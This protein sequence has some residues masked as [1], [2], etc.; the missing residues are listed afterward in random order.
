MAWILTA[1][2]G[3]AAQPE[4]QPPQ[5]EPPAT[6]AHDGPHRW[7]GQAE[8]GTVPTNQVLSPLGQQIAFP[9]RPTALAMSPDGRF[10]GV[11]CSDQVV[12]IDLDRRNIA[13]QAVHPGGS[14]TGIVFAPGGQTLLASSTRGRIEQYAVAANGQLKRAGRIQLPPPPKGQTAGVI[15][16]GL[17]LDPDRKT[18]WAALNGSNL[19]AQIDLASGKLLRT[20]AV[21][22]APFDVVCA[23]GK[24]YVSN[25]GGRRP[26]AKSLVGPSGRAA[27]VRVDPRC[28]IASEGS[29]SVV[30]PI[31]GRAV[32]EIVAGVHSC[33]LAVSPDERFV[34]VANA[35]SDTVSVIDTRRDEVARSLSTHLARGLPL[36]SAPNGLAFSG[37]GRTLYVANGTNNALAVIAFDRALQGAGAP[38]DASHAGSPENYLLGCL[39]TGWYPAGVA[40]DPR[41]EAIYV[42]NIKG[43]GSRN[44]EAA[45]LRKVKGNTVWGYSTLQPRGTV[46]LI[47]LHEAADLPRH[48][49]TVLANNRIAVL[50]RALSNP[51]VG[52]APRP[53][54]ERHGEPSVFKH[55]IYIIKENRTYDQVFGDLPE[56]EGDPRLCIFGDEITPNHHKLAKEFVLLDNFYCSGVL[57]ADGHQWTDEA[58]ATDYIE[59]SFGEWPRSYPYD[60]NDA[61]AYARS[62]FLWDNALAHGRSLRIYGEFVQPTV[63]WKEPGRKAR[64]TF[65]DCYHDFR[66]RRGQI[67]IHGRA[68]IKSLEPYVCPADVSFPNTVSDQYRADVFLRE[69]AAFERSGNMPSLSIMSLPNN[70]TSG[71]APGMPTPEAA[72]ADND[73]ALGQIV[74]GVSR[75][76]FWPE[77]CIFVVEDDP[78]NGFDHIDGHRTVALVIS[79]YT[80]RHVVD[81]TSYNQT[82]MVRT[83]ELI[84]GLPPMNQLDAA[85]TPMANGFAAWANLTPYTAVP[86]RIPLDRLNPEISQI[87]DP[88]QRHW[89]AVSLHLPLDDVDEA[90][91]DTLNRILW[92][93]RRGRDDTYPAWAVLGGREKDSD[94]PSQ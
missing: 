12:T 34:C 31:Q 69:L 79:P 67:E 39:P 91:E 27:D 50:R 62:G 33:A 59:K 54:P 11:L 72:V 29:V 81:S 86:S 60:G 70:H 22:N 56:G 26:D 47:A 5:G 51:R 58:Y 49:A 16:A 93:A 21:G 64:P 48:T 40:F 32:K 83:I 52:V 87:K 55:V 6:K 90:D 85:A 41:R 77:T 7:V 82:S 30:D 80:R 63:R 13:G 44:V 8:S 75:S 66:E 94:R 45:N 42:A 88:R 25:W 10:L 37:D 18:L 4:S 84:L 73:L 38:A 17:A 1:G 92:H 20:I 43:G 19:L 23:A 71:T 9:S 68:T 35:N 15:P 89:A 53:I 76:K 61:M 28:Y 3:A 78:Q 36:G 74:A 65:L 57:S 14:Y 24:V 46:S 2:R